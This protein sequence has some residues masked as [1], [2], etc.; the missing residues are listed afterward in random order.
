MDIVSMSTRTI[1]LLTLWACVV[2]GCME[3]QQRTHERA[4]QPTHNTAGGYIEACDDMPGM[5]GDDC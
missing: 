5:L 2:A 3:L 4:G 1:I